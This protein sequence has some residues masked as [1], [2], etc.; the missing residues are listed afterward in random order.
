MLEVRESAEVHF[1][2]VSARLEALS[3]RPTLPLQS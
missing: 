2:D 3:R 1:A